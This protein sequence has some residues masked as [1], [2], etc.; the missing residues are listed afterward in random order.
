MYGK[1]ILIANK[2][3]SSSE[4]GRVLVSESTK[5]ILEDNYPTHYN[6][7]GR[8]LINIPSIET[9]ITGYFL[10]LDLWY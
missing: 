5:K 10:D 1:D 6:F 2:M 8:K 4:E 3:E 7:V 9:I